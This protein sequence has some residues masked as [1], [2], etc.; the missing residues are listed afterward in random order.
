MP[1][2]QQ[3]LLQAQRRERRCL[4]PQQQLGRQQQQQQ[5][6]LEAPGAQ[7]NEGQP[8]ASVLDWLGSSWE[9]HRLLLSLSL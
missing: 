2:L 5:Q 1:A 8:L 4:Q 7:F 9:P 6:Q 3:Q